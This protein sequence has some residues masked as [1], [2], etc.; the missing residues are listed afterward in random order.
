MSIYIG[1]MSGTSLDG[2]DVVA[3]T[4]HDSQAQILAFQH[5]PFPIKLK[6]QI[7]HF[8]EGNALTAKEIGEMDHQLGLL[9]AESICHFLLQ[10]HLKSSQITAIG[11][12]G[13]TVFHQPIGNTAFT[14][15]LGDPNLIAAHT[16]IT[17]VCD[18]RRKDM[19]FGGQGAP[20]VPAFHQYLFADDHECRVVLNLGGIANIT[21]LEP[22]KAVIGFD[23]GPANMLIDGWIQ[24][25]LN[26]PFDEEGQWAS[27]GQVDH[28]FLAQ[29]LNE[30]YFSLPTPKS[31]GRELFHQQW[32]DQQLALYPPNLSK[33]D[34]QATLLALTATVSAMPL[35]IIHKVKFWFVVAVGKILH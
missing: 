1:I 32:L 24:R 16:G 23:T 35:K 4:F 9:Y 27:Q 2:V 22:H 11:C 28:G 12:H 33:E 20:L 14:W 18:F 6:A 26:L 29:L 34:V 21:V 13:Q 15:Q 7:L 30:P 17:T 8:S 5:F 3:A 31:T 25:H 10:H 19:A